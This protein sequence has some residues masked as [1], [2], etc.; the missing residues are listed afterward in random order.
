MAFLGKH[1]FLPSTREQTL[2]Q[3]MLTPTVTVALN[4][5]NF[6]RKL[7]EA[8]SSNDKGQI[9]GDPFYSSHGYKMRIFVQLNEA[10]HGF[11]GYMGVYLQLMQGD[12]DDCLK[13]PFDKR[14]TFIVVDQQDNQ[15][16]VD[17]FEKRMDPAGEK[18]FDKPSVESKVGHGLPKFMLHSALRSRQYVR[19]HTVY[20]AVA[21]EP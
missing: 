21:I 1:T 2:E 4:I 11:T 5:P 8:N 7:N 15:S 12:N 6:T 10:F 14:V 3:L 17:N 18:S 13:W 16:Q 9:N 19:N 20:I